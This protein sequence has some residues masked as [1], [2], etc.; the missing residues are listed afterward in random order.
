MSQ[1]YTIWA[2]SPSL[3][4]QHR[5]LDLA[6]TQPIED[7]LLAQ[8]H[9]DSFAAQ[10]NYNQKQHATDWVGVIKLEQVGI[11]TIPGYLFHS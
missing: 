11:Q 5:L 8:R 1:G 9:A 2:Y 7:Q 6:N 4:E 10:Y 3:N